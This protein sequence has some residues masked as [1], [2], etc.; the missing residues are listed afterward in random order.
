MATKGAGTKVWVLL[1][2]NLPLGAFTL[3]LIRPK[4]THSEPTTYTSSN[5]IGVL[6][7]VIN[8]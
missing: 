1:F 7:L 8:S 3:F 2:A 5:N 6:M 4:M